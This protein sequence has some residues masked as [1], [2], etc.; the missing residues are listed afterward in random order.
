[1]KKTNRATSEK[2]SKPA[3]AAIDSIGI[4]IGDKVSHYCRL[5]T[6]GM[7]AEEQGFYTTIT[8]GKAEKSEKS[9]TEKRDRL[10]WTPKL[11]HRKAEKSG[12][13]SCERMPPGVAFTRVWT[14]LRLRRDSLGALPGVCCLPSVLG[15]F[16][17]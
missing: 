1:M 15:R 16:S 8:S 10:V 2:E 4:D 17:S 5:D 7:I 12:T 14:S 9:G 13:G 3:L 11:R 6:E